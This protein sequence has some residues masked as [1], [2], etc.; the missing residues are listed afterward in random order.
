MGGGDRN[1]GETG[2]RGESFKLSRFDGDFWGI[3]TLPAASV[4]GGRLGVVAEERVLVVG[5]D[6]GPVD[7]V[8]R[9]GLGSCWLFFRDLVPGARGVFDLAGRVGDGSREA[10]GDGAADEAAE[11]CEGCDVACLVDGH[12]SVRGVTVLVVDSRE[13]VGCEER[14]LASVEPF[15][16]FVVDLSMAADMGGESSRG[17]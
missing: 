17:G 9:A 7:L 11:L 2:H 3:D 15:P 1:R 5:A 14:L 13:R 10:R 6:V 4:G 12:D 8:D 16:I